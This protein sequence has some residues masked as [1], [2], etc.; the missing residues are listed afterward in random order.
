MIGIVFGDRVD[1]LEDTLWPVLALLLY[2]TFTQVP[3]VHL[4]EVVADTGLI[5]S[6]IV[7]NFLVIPF[8]VWGLMHLLPDEPAIRLGVLMVLLVPCTDWF[9]TFT[10]LGGGDT[11]HAIAFSPIS[12]LLQIALLPLYLWLFVGETFS[13]TLARKEMFYAFLGLIVLPLLC[14][15]LTERWV[16]RSPRR[17]QLIDKLGWLPVPLLGL[18]VFVIAATQV[19]LITVS[20]GALGRLLTVFVAFLIISGLLSRLVAGVF[21]LPTLQGRVLAFSMGTRN[22]FVVLPLALALPPSCE[23]A[24]VAIVFQSLVELVG[25]VFYLWWVPKWLF[26]LRED[27]R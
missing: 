19:N 18:V 4:K 27:Y 6:A 8:V 7:G 3:L 23:L 10:H 15:Y 11:K 24:V 25:M 17:S 20:L 9:I 16:E 21:R 13:I 2:S 26:P 12:L 1:L 22:S 5:R 14:A